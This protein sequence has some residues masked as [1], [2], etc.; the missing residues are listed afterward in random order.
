[1]AQALSII[2]KL[3]TPS[4]FIFEGKTDSILFDPGR[5]ANRIKEALAN[6]T[7]ADLPSVLK[8]EAGQQ[9]LDNYYDKV[10]GV[11]SL[12]RVFRCYTASEQDRLHCKRQLPV[13]V[14][15]NPISARSGRK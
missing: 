2:Q 9:R 6:T 8:Q 14:Q 15:K 4:R 7:F 11:A 13:T 12:E 10:D 1:M 3:G 5:H